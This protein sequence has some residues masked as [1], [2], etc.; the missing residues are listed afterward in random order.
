MYYLVENE[1]G[2][3]WHEFEEL[4]SIIQKVIRFEKSLNEPKLRGQ[5]YKPEEQENT[6]SDNPYSHGASPTKNAEITNILFTEML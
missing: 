5:A 1:T 4:T 3:K 6:S 2:S